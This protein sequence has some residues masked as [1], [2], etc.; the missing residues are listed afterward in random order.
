MFVFFKQKPAYEMRISDW[1]SD[2]CSSDLE[3]A[4]KIPDDIKWILRVDGHTDNVP[5]ATSRFPSNWELS[6]ARAISVVKFL[7]EQ[8]ISP[9][10]LVAAGFGEVQPLDTRA[11]EIARRPHRRTQTKTAPRLGLSSPDRQEEGR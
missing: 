4:A 3:I 9:D 10:R 11:A 5:I 1:S 7:I 2:V 8:G 6:T